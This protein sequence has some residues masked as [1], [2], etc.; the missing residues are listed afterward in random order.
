MPQAAGFLLTT[1]GDSDL[2]WGSPTSW[3]YLEC[4]PADEEFLSC[5]P[6]YVC[7]CHVPAPWSMISCIHYRIDTGMEPMMPMCSAENAKFKGSY[8]TNIKYLWLYF[9]TF[10]FSQQAETAKY[11]FPYFFIKLEITSNSTENYRMLE[12]KLNNIF[13][14][15][16]KLLKF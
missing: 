6:S 3:G 7:M 1:G 4:E 2:W 16:K 14:S 10:F 11:I 15:F 5:S 12:H 8:Y 9:S 13:F